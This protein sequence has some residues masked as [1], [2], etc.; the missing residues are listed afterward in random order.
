MVVFSPKEALDWFAM[1]R[2]YDNSLGGVTQPS[3]RR[4]AQFYVLQY[5]GMLLDV[6]FQNI[7][8]YEINKVPYYVREEI[9]DA[10]PLKIG[11]KLF[12]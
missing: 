4:F 1:K 5:E 9:E 3:Q 8:I 6:L 12:F 10:W 7:S 2:F 11:R